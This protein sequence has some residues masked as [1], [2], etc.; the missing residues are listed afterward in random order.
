MN[1]RTIGYWVATALTAFSYITGGAVD[2]A[3]PDFAV[4]E[5]TNLGYPVYFMVIL[6]VWKMLGG[7]VVLLPKTPLLKEWAYFGMFLNLTSAAISHIVI[8]DPP[9]ET[10]LPLVI[11]AIVATSWAL[12]PKNR[13]LIAANDAT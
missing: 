4:E 6:G 13:T 8:G 11:L 7:I 2:V 3:R 12:R 5:I 1:K 10:A 9:G